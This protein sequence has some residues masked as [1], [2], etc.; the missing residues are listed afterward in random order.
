MLGMGI[1]AK[2]KRGWD[3]ISALV[4]GSPG[5]IR[6]TLEKRILVCTCNIPGCMRE[7]ILEGVNRIRKLWHA[8][9]SMKE[10]ADIV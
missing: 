2:A 5:R 8:P 7:R 10:K 1:W 4:F 9:Y 6:A 3:E